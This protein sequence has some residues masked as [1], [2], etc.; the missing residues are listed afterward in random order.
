MTLILSSP[1][2]EVNPEEAISRNEDRHCG[3]APGRQLR[4]SLVY[5]RSCRILDYLELCLGKVASCVS[6]EIVSI[7]G[8]RVAISKIGKSAWT[9]PELATCST[10]LG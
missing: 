8:K 9:C 5:R 4:A 1:V 3:G 7:E 2:G 6:R 10:D